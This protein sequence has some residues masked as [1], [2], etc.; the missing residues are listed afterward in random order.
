MDNEKY[1]KSYKEFMEQLMQNMPFLKNAVHNLL[2]RDFDY[3]LLQDEAVNEAQR[4]IDE[5]LK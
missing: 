1:I 2:V 4:I 3:Q 5:G